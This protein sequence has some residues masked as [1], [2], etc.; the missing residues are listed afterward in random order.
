MSIVNVN[1]DTGIRFGII[2]AQS[3]EPDVINDIKGTGRDVRYEEAME[4]LRIEVNQ[5]V[6]NGE[7]EEDDFDTELDKR[8]IEL[9]DNWCD[10]E[11]IYEF[12]IDEVQG[13]TTWLGGAM[14]VWVFK[15]PRTTHARLCSPCVPNCGDLDSI[16]EDGE[17]CYDVPLKWRR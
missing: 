12:D 3:L 9:S 8:A 14:M 6:E 1:L 5:A 11:P 4:K 16:D 2:S 13:R 7:I 17:K 10:G 15:S